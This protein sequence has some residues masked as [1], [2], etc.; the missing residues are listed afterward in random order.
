M[1]D[2]WVFDTSAYASSKR[3]EW[4]FIT[5]KGNLLR[6][7]VSVVVCLS[8]CPSL[9]PSL[10]LSV[11]ASV[12]LSVCLSLFS[13]SLCLHFSLLPRSLNII[14]FSSPL[15]SSLLFTGAEKPI[16]RAGHASAPLTL[17]DGNMYM[18]IHGGYVI[19]ISLF[20][21]FLSVFSH[22]PPPPSSSPRFS[23]FSP[24]SLPSLPLPL[25]FSQPLTPFFH[26]LPYSLSNKGILDDTF[27]LST[28]CKQTDVNN[29]KCSD[30]SGYWIRVKLTGDSPGARFGHY[31]LRVYSNGAN[32]MY[33]LGGYGYQ[34]YF[35]PQRW[36]VLP[37]ERMSKRP[38]TQLLNQVARLVCTGLVAVE[39][40]ERVPD[41]DGNPL[42]N[43]KAVCAW[44]SST[45]SFSPRRSFAVSLNTHKQI[46]VFSGVGSVETATF[47][48]AK[49]GVYTGYNKGDSVIFSV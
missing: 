28:G 29:V 10:C 8:S 49:T 11:S 22:F 38:N 46:I 42:M 18:V 9:C 34:N 5:T 15:L 24:L 33:T 30:F 27:L 4:H 13:V 41:V 36:D 37:A 1:D 2:V 21:H 23:F 48:L 31:G 17:P 45:G 25:P 19:S 20:C 32:S 44:G 40:D 26:H 35:K 14:S 12:C 6:S 43:Q 39:E 3:G 16:A 47:N 7:L